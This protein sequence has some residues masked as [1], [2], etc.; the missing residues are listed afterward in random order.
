VAARFRDHGGCNALVN[1]RE[2]YR[3]PSVLENIVTLP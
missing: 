1:E 3:P 2:K